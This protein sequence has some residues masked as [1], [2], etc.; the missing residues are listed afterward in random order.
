MVHDCISFYL[1]TVMSFT[2]CSL[3]FHAEAVT[4]DNFIAFPKPSL[5]AYFFLEVQIVTAHSVTG[6]L[7]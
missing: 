6:A 1:S 4:L 5:A 3:Y 2:L 7:S